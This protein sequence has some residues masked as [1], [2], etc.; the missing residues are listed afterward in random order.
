M[1]QTSAPPLSVLLRERT[2]AAHAAAEHSPFLLALA[3][4]RVTPAGVVGL[5]Q[6]LLPVYDELEQVGLLWAADPDVGPLLVPGLERAPSLRADLASL[7][8]LPST[9]SS[10]AWDYAQRIRTAGA[11]SAAAYVAHHY[12][13]YL[14]DLSGGQ[15]V[16]QALRNTLGVDLSFFR[17]P[18]LRGPV[19]KREYRAHLDSRTWDATR[20]EEAVLEASLAFRFNQDLAAE[21]DGE[22]ANS[23][24]VP[25]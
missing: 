23:A 19:V 22:I 14:G 5:L 13:R 15:V 6:R 1:T 7:G 3:Q 12:T 16:G 17:F 24:Q 4:G 20:Q 25:T 18:R 11:R 21:L 2:A 10:A 8:A 9:S